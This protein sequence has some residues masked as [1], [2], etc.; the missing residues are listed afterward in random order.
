MNKITIEIT[1]DS[2]TEKLEVDGQVIV[3]GWK[4]T[5]FGMQSTVKPCW[6]DDE[7]VSDEAYE[8]LGNLACNY[9]DAMNSLQA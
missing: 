7:R 2:V 6:E 1:A 8:A 5:A 3:K 9:L 4:R